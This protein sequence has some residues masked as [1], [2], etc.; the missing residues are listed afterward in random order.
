ML[1]INSND[2]Y[3]CLSAKTSVYPSLT[4][5]SCI[6]EGGGLFVFVLFFSVMCVWCVF[7]ADSPLPLYS[8]DPEPVPD[9]PHPE[10]P[11]R[12]EGAALA[13]LI[14]FFT[15]AIHQVQSQTVILHSGSITALTWLISQGFSFNA[16]LCS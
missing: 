9:E 5:C 7:G 10:A 1:K 2:I 13:F 16:Q 3:K 12:E 8:S 15:A 4:S 6:Y 11:K 14:S